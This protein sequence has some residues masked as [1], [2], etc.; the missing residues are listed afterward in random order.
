MTDRATD[1]RKKIN[2]GSV[3]DWPMEMRT[4]ESGK[5]KGGNGEEPSIRD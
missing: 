4:L 1:G 2:V 5:P 3:T